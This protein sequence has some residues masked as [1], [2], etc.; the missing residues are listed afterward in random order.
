[1]QGKIAMEEHFALADTFTNTKR[2]S[3]GMS[4]DLRRRLMDIHDIR[5]GEMDEFGIE[6]AIQSLNAPGVQ[7]VV[8]VDKAVDLAR[9]ANDIL[10]E[11]VAKR[12]DRF[13]G[14]AALPLQDPDAAIVELTRCIKELGFK[15]TMVNGFTHQG[16]PE[17][18]IYYDLPQYRPFWASVEELDMPFYLH[19]RNPLPARMQNLQ[20]HPWLENSPWAFAMETAVHALRL[21]GSGIFD[22]FP[23][24]KL[25][26][27]HLGE[28]IP[29]DLWRVDHRI[30]KSPQG[31]P[32]KQTMR[33]YMQNNVHLTTSGNFNDPTFH[34]TVAEVGMD[35]ILFSVDY[36]FETTSD[37]AVWFDNMEMDE[38]DRLAVGRTNA[39][40]LFKLN[41]L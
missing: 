24:L 20:G 29:F 16:D 14:F 30:K 9:R 13:A 27:G 23:N 39:I 15:G 10:A 34:C 19:P 2:F 1:M 3:T 31:I 18:V 40:E 28:R 22:E 5:L 32:A 35:R 8:E 37:A 36:P 7:S 38:A 25:V 41:V 17:S 33:Y 4:D 21:M 12:P 11:E 26:L 6:L